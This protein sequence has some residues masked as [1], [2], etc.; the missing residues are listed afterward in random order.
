M[1]NAVQAVKQVPGTLKGFHANS[2]GTGW[3]QMFDKPIVPFPTP[4]SFAIWRWLLPSARKTLQFLNHY[5]RLV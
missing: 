5:V 3:L 1:S 2:A 4:N